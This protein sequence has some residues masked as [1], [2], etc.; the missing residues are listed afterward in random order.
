MKR[1]KIPSNWGEISA[2]HLIQLEELE[3][4]KDSFA[5]NEFDYLFEQLAILCNLE[6]SD[7]DVL[8]ELTPNDIKV[9]VKQLQWFKD[10]VPSFTGGYFEWNDVKYK[11]IDFNSMSVAEWITIEGYVLNNF[12]AN[13]H[14]LFASIYRKVKEDEWGNEIT[15]P[16]TFDFNKRADEFML[17]PLN[18]LPIKEF[19]QFREDCYTYFDLTNKNQDDSEEPVPEE[20]LEEDEKLN[21]RQKAVQQEKLEKERLMKVF[22]W[23]KLMLGFTNNNIVDSYKVLELPIIYVFRAITVQKNLD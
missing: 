10:S 16:F 1:L 23:E 18:K 21:Y 2:L 9:I 15:E 12:K 22:N 5:N 6:S 3:L 19:L 14:N 4:E 11:K 20:E 8:Y 17:A 7:D 13:A